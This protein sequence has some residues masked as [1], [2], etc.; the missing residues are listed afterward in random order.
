M[1]PYWILLPLLIAG[2]SEPPAVVIP[3]KVVATHTIHAETPVSSLGY[4]GEVRARHETT[5]AF[6]VAGKLLTRKVD[7]G[8]AV[9]PGQL[10]AQIDGADYAAAARAASAEKKLAE[11]EF[12]RFDT[13]QQ[14]GFVSGQAIDV[15]RAQR[16]AAV[17]RAV[18]A[19]NQLRYASLNADVAGVV[20]A[21]LAEPGQVVAAGQPVVRVARND[22]LEVLIAVPESRIEALAELQRSGASAKVTLWAAPRKTYQ[23]KVREISPQ[24]DAITRTYAVRVAL[25]DADPV[26]RL[27]MTATVVMAAPA[28]EPAWLIPPPALFQQGNQPAVWVID[29]DNRVHLRPI[30]VASIDERAV[31]VIGGVQDGEEIVAAGAHKLIE[32]ELVRRMERVGK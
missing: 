23:G 12:K 7:V 20:S 22:A 19:D 24:A 25:T 26:V 2:C 13:L 18:V 9:K 11:A 1:K 17:A 10:L 27:G 30:K 15:R 8:E 14:Q 31:R 5:L 3:P 4:S 16:D 32:N 6:R 28:A 21:V 29:N